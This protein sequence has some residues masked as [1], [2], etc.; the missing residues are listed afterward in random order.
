MLAISLSGRCDTMT[1]EEHRAP[2]SSEVSRLESEVG[3]HAHHPLLH[4]RVFE[5]LKRRNVRS[6]GRNSGRKMA[7]R[8]LMT[9]RASIAGFCYQSLEPCDG[10]VTRKRG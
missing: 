3:P 1:T 6:G 7:G 9:R 8:V 10:S 4:L 2:L 5:Q